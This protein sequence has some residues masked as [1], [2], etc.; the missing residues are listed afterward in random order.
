MHTIVVT[1]NDSSR[2]VVELVWGQW[3]LNDDNIVLLLVSALRVPAVGTFPKN[4]EFITMMNDTLASLFIYP[5]LF[6]VIVGFDF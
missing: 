2:F 6:L 1:Q 5:A 4:D 3:W